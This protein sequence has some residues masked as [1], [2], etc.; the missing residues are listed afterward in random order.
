MALNKSSNNMSK[1]ALMVVV[2]LVASQITPSHSLGLGHAFV[3]NK[4]GRK[5][6]IPGRQEVQAVSSTAK[7]RPRP[8]NGS[9]NP[10]NGHAFTNNKI[11][12]KLLIT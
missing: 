2:L 9:N 11:G 7:Q 8:S 3:N 4:I 6:W 10:N 12:R 1:V 5:P